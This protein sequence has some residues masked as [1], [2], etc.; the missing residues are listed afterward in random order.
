MNKVIIGALCLTLFS[1]GG[2]AEENADD[3]VEIIDSIDVTSE[4]VIADFKYFEDY[5]NLK[6]KSELF[7]V[8][9]DE[10]LADDTAWY[11][12]GELMLMC[13]DLVN[14]DNGWRVR[15]VWDEFE[16]ETLSFIEATF[17][18]YDNDYNDLGTQ[19]VEASNGLYTGMTLADVIAWNDGANFQFSG[20]GWDY[21]GGVTPPEG[22]KIEA[23]KVMFSL[24]LD[25]TK[26][27]FEG[28]DSLIGDSM[29]SSD[30]EDALRAPIILYYMSYFSE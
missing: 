25:P 16:P 1:C 3:T 7:T 30:E 11:A 8:F 13:T 4:F 14:P 6:T 9:G 19:K 28:F 22:S 15:Y 20:F 12:E 24:S 23:S 26:E 18:N 17:Q 10:N 29:H 5:A 21:E 2:A 27:F